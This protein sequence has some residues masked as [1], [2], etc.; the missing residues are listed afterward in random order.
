M[1][2]LCIIGNSHLG[3][4]KMGW[5]RIRAEQPGLQIT[6]AGSPGNK[7]KRMQIVDG[8]LEPAEYWRPMFLMTT[9][10]KT[11]IDPALYDAFVL[12]GATFGIFPLTK[13]H[14]HYRAESHACRDAG[15]Q[16]V[17]D[18]MFHDAALDRLRGSLAFRVLRK[19]R[20]VTDKPVYIAPEPGPSVAIVDGKDSEHWKMLIESGDNRRL[21]DT[22][23][24]CSQELAGNGLTILD[25]PSETIA[26]AIFS[27]ASFTR[28]A[29]ALD[30]SDMPAEHDYL[31]M[32]DVYGAIVM[33]RLLERMAIPHRAVA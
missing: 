19:L 3:A 5:N 7:I 15:P 27:K 6:F 18:E 31:H 20:Q 11:N 29:V 26:E 21:A 23:R 4:V 24:A 1:T 10:G 2:H 33:Q 17:S 8:K 12:V 9:G 13:L 25:Q 16:L 28:G 30:D 22:L 14:Y 32:N